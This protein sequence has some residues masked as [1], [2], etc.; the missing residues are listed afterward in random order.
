MLAKKFL[1][2][3]TYHV[4]K[5]LLFVCVC[6]MRGGRWKRGGKGAGGHVPGGG[7]DRRALGFELRCVC[8]FWANGDC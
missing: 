2:D 4:R 7:E 8:V 6:V 5:N 3:L 1:R